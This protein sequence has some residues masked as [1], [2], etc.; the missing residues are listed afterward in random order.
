MSTQ[1]IESFLCGEWKSGSGTGSELVNPTTEAVIATAD[2]TGLDFAAAL[3]FARDTGGPALR[4]MTFAER[5]ELLQRMSTAIHG[6]REPLIDSA[7]ANGGCTRSDAKF[8]VDGA[9]GTLASYAELGK[10]LGDRT[11]LAD[12]DGIQLGRSPRFWG[13]HVFVPRVG[14]AVFI[15]A[16][17]FPAWGFAEKAACALLAG[18]PVLSK[19]AT[20]TAL[21]AYLMTKAIVDADAAPAGA[22]SFVGGRPGD[23]LDHLGPQDVLAFT[24]SAQ[25]GRTLRSRPN[26][27]ELGV[28]VNVEADSLNCAIL[29][30]DV[31]LGSDTMSLFVR[32]VVRDMTQ[33]TGQKCTAVRRIIVPEDSVDDVVEAMGEAFGDIRIGDPTLRDVRMGP[34][35][36][37]AQLRAVTEGVAKLREE[38]DVVWGDAGRPA[39]LTN[40]EG[41]V[42]YF[43]SIMLLKARNSHDAPNVHSHEVFGPVSTI[44]P[45]NGKSA[46]AVK[47]AS[48]GGG[49]LVSSVFSDDRK[50]VGATTVGLAPH[51]GRIY[52]GSEK[53]AEYATGPGLVLPTCVHGGPGRAGGGEEL[54]G[55]RGVQHFMQRTAIQGY[56]AMVEHISGTRPKS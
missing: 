27:V 38:A 37:K 40:I 14:V 15:N 7:I 9:I 8:D 30:P 46:D 53:V 19:P 55:V 1:R 22:M 6:A 17:N 10:E 28:P 18:M 32:D 4:A 20:A 36:S 35:A 13:Q 16:F 11:F 51:H 56:R 24:G 2:T 5:G 21:T 45:Y 31:E 26:L 34:L 49:G 43:H 42:G 50:F 25:V 39:S 12:G 47:L 44:L 3:A 41:E 33:K 52:L 54:G 23:M 29:G 48:L